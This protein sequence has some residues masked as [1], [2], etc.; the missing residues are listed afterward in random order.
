[1]HMMVPVHAPN[2]TIVTKP[3]Q[4]RAKNPALFV[5]VRKEFPQASAEC[6]RWGISVV[7]FFF[8]FLHLQSRLCALRLARSRRT[9]SHELQPLVS[10]KLVVTFPYFRRHTSFCALW[11]CSS[12]RSCSTIICSSLY[13]S[14]HGT[15][16]SSALVLTTHSVLPPMLRPFLNHDEIVFA[17]DETERRVLAG[18]MSCSADRRSKNVSSG[19]TEWIE[20]V[21]DSAR[22][23]HV[24]YS[25]PFVESC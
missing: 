7:F 10:K 22:N 15:P 6:D 1:M 17:F 21:S 9:R 3:G 2:P 11:A 25:V 16:S 8:F 23:L 24:R 18:I 20:D 12:A 14:A 19:W 13:A 5:C 4:V